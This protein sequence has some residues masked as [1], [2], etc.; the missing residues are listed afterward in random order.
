M[1]LL[2]ANTG[3][4]ITNPIVPLHVV[5]NGL[6]TGIVSA[7]SFTGTATSAI[8]AANINGGTRG[9]I[10]FQSGTNATALLSPGSSG[11]VLVT[12]GGGQ[13]PYW[14]SINAVSGAFNGITISD[15]GS[16]IGA[17]GSVSILN[18]VGSN[19][20]ATVSGNISTITVSNDA[21]YLTGVA[22]GSVI[23]QSNGLSING[24][25]NVTG[26]V[27]IGG[28]STTLS[29]TTLQ[30]RDRDIVL[31]VTTDLTENEIST[32]LTATHGGIAVASTVGN[33]LI[34]F[35]IQ[36]GINSFP[37]TYKQ[38]MWIR[39]GAYSG[40]GTDAWVS[41]YALS[42]GN[43]S[44][45]ISGSRLTVGVGFTVYDNLLYVPNI[46]ATGISTL[47]SVKISSGIITSPSPGVSTVFYYGNGSGLTNI[48]A[49]S[50][51]GLAGTFSISTSTSSTS[52]YLAFV[53]SASTTAIGINTFLSFVPSTGNLGIGSAS[54]QVKVDVIGNAKFVGVITATT[55]SGQVNAG[56]GTI[57][58][59]TSTNSNI[60]N[61]QIAG[62]STITNGPV[63][64]GSGTSTGIALQRLQ[65]TGGAYI[66]GSLGVGISAPTQSLHVVGN[67]LA[68]GTVTANSDIKLKENVRTIDNAL[69]KVLSLR[70]VEYD[71]IDNGE[72]QIGVIA[73]E[74][75]EVI[76]EVVYP[77]GEYPD[78]ETKS[79]AYANLIGL[80]IEAI[81]EQNQRIEEL[82]RKVGDI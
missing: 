24:N 7:L 31:G 2:K 12:G 60:T 48:S 32:D 42:I 21:Q 77:K 36:V 51:I 58:V 61:I 59:L 75:E 78:Y 19:I 53:S 27:S 79:V 50:L 3:I 16:I 4:G 68:S 30:I 41:N 56:V 69:S 47:G 38:F 28:T 73:Q 66:S 26:T 9:S 70:G 18:F 57:T 55:F 25:L 71:R 76:P 13:D 54:P 20:S 82:E 67:I 46:V 43:T 39:A 23:T 8:S 63:L 45:V 40:M 14:A 72:H 6:F 52:Q 34:N 5:G 10:P 15:E 65:V 49:D 22:P 35:P 80:L 64:I 33:P 74:V 29:A 44:T 62:I 1:A 11:N 17:A 37:F 81:K